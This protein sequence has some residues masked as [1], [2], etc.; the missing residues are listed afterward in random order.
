MRG[1]GTQAPPASRGSGLTE[2]DR[3]FNDLTLDNG[4]VM[5]VPPAFHQSPHMLP[6]MKGQWHGHDGRRHTPTCLADRLIPRIGP[7]P[8]T[9]GK[10]LASPIGTGVTMAYG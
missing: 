2:P 8:S 9:L 7:M 6:E 4:T 10:Y 5:T 1:V 3:P